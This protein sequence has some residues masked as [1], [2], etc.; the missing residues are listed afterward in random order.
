M[1]TFYIHSRPYLYFLSDNFNNALDQCI[2]FSKIIQALF[3]L[4]FT[5]DQFCHLQFDP[6]TNEYK[7]CQNFVDFDIAELCCLCFSKRKTT[8]S[9]VAITA[10]IKHKLKDHCLLLF[11]LTPLKDEIEPN[12]DLELAGDPLRLVRNVTFP[13]EHL[14]ELVVLKK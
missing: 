11:D 3:T 7:K 6:G 2:G 10:F 12:Y 1:K 8:S 4:S 9:Q 5:K 14:T 13:L